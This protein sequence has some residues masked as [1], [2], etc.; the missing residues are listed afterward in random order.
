M[1][2]WPN[3]FIV[4]VAK[5]GTTSLY[6]YLSKIPQIY[7]SPVKEPN[8]FNQLIELNKNQKLGMD[9]KRYLSLF[10]KVKNEKIVGE[11]SISYLR[12]PHTPT[13]IREQIPDALILISLRDPVERAFSSFLNN[14]R[15]RKLK[16]SFH[17]QLNQELKNDMDN[18][19]TYIRLN[20]GLY[21]ENVKRYL[22][23]FGPEQVKIVIFEEWVKNLKDTLEEILKFLGLNPHLKN[24]E[25]KT[26]NPYVDTRGAIAERILQS[27]M[28]INLSQSLISESSKN[29]LKKIL[30]KKQTKPKMSQED[31]KTLTDFYRNDVNKVQAL[32][33]R[34][35]LWPNF[36]SEVDFSNYS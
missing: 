35:L 20:A 34:N 12:N 2:K 10:S 6:T 31:R 21:F 30:F 29:F 16:A 5:A 25:E 19:K 15:Y 18:N 32:L 33:G 4:G 1:E 14:R 23:T 27:K 17:E 11:A 8:Y 13:L 22:E 28:A 24:F 36:K 7:M 9:K 26:H 3:F